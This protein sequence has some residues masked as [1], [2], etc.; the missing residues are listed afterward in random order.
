MKRPLAAFTAGLALV[1]VS[2]SSTKA[3]TSPPTTLTVLAASSLTGVFTTLAQQFEHDHPGTTVWFSFGGSDSLAAEIVD[4]APAD[5]F[6]A[7]SPK[8]MAI[9]TAHLLT[10]AAP[11][12]I[13]R[14]ELEIAVP[15]G[16][17]AHI[18]G[19]ADLRRAGVKLAVCAYTVPCGAAA[20]KILPTDAHPVTFE[21]DVKAVLAKVELGEVDAGLVY[22][23]DVRAA[24]GRVLGISFPQAARAITAY[25]IA[26]L[27]DAP[28]PV[29]AADFMRFVLSARAQ[30]LLRAAGFLPP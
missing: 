27:K 18:H 30:R 26:M 3:N 6:A 10:A 7:A 24:A 8:T 20:H 12:V 4:G 28:H 21:L 2:C 13:A 14:N 22:V 15:P 9:V 16:N 11:V 5:V 1:A 19:L 29:A 17:P 23:T 25:P